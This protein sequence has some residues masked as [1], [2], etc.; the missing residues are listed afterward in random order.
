MGE[1]A[2]LVDDRRQRR[3][4][5]RLVERGEQQ[6]QKQRAEDRR[7]RWTIDGFRHRASEHP[8]PPSPSMQQPTGRLEW[9]SD[10]LL[11]L[12]LVGS[13]RRV[14]YAY[15]TS[16]SDQREMGYQGAEEMMSA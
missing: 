13:M 12:K 16:W 5:D 6:D 9:T 1:A 4:Y 2:E 10:S 11:P 15:S 3:R 7:D 8:Q 14:N